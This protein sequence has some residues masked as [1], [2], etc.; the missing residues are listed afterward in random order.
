MNER[1]N[2]FMIEFI[3]SSEWLYFTL[4]VPLLSFVLMELSC[5]TN[6]LALLILCKI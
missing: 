4:T 6:P 1:I 2:E 5:I 3:A